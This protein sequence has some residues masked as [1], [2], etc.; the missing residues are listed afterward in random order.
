MPT[1]P[2]PT[3]PN[4]VCK[5]VFAGSLLEAQWMN[6]MWLFLTGSGEITAGDLTTL[7][8]GCGS[9][10]ADNF[11]PLLSVNSIIEAVEVVLYD[12]VD[13]DLSVVS[14]VAVPGSISTAGD[15]AGV[16]ACISWAIRAHYR[17]GHPRTYL[18]GLANAEEG[19]ATSWTTAFQADLTSGAQAFHSAIEGLGPIGAGITD[20]EHGVVSFVLN[21]A[22]RTP[23]VFRRILTAVVDSRMDTQ[24]R[25]LGKD[26]IA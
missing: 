13:G 7:A 6:V 22:W 11:M 3:P 1:G 5:L 10:Y 14:T 19:S 18:C 25:R 8:E 24:R 17:G 9:A 16:S 12:S 20:V 23:P 4:R 21:N 2:R 26:R 15:N